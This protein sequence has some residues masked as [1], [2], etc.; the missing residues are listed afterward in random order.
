MVFYHTL[1]FEKVIL[2]L[3]GVERGSNLN[4]TRPG[5]VDLHNLS[6]RTFAELFQ[7]WEI[8]FNSA[9]THQDLTV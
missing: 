1:V 4:Y 2:T 7:K 9:T 6:F 8:I 5:K 3:I